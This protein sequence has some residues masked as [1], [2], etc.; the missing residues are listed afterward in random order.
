[1]LSDIQEWYVP[2]GLC[3]G[4]IALGVWFRSNLCAWI[5]IVMNGLGIPLGVLLSVTNGWTFRN[6]I[7]IVLM[8]Y[9][10]HALW[11]RTRYVRLMDE[12]AEPPSLRKLLKQQDDSALASGVYRLLLMA[13][14][15][16]FDVVSLST[17]QRTVALVSFA[18]EA[19][20]GGNFENLLEQ[21]VIGDPHFELTVEAFRTLGL[22]RSI[23]AFVAVKD[24]FP[25]GLIPPDPHDRLNAFLEKEDAWREQLAESVHEEGWDGVRETKLAEYIRANVSEFRDL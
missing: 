17:A 19:I 25:S 1:M 14:D 12:L 9:T 18:A 15:Y 2:V 6:T 11:A 22:E 5:L 4:V 3:M 20:D 13:N 24:V 7:K 8:A 16:E 23:R 10:A 21:E